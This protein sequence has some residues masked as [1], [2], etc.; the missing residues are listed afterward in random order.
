MSEIADNVARVRERITEAANRAGR[1]SDE[2]TLAAVTKKK[3][4]SA[5]L[6]ALAAGVIDVGENYVQ[7][8]EEKRELLWPSQIAASRWHLLGHLQSNKAKLAVSL[9]DLIQSVDSVKLAAAISRQPASEPQAILLQVHLGDEETKTGFAPN[10]A[11]DAASEIAALPNLSL[12][13]LMGIAPNGTDPRPYFQEL[14]R[15]FD[16]LPEANRQILSMGM[17]GDFE[18]AI[19]EGA[20]LVRVGTAIFGAR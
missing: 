5:V 14:K 7:E 10:L 1:N 19:E 18:T 2:I 12:R 9:F 11:L 15:L 13:G 3:P 4:A 16:A 8:A 17:S 20:T 6:E